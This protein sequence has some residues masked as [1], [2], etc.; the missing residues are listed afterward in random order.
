MSYFDH[1]TIE[2]LMIYSLSSLFNSLKNEMPAVRASQIIYHLN[3]LVKQHAL[4]LKSIK[5][6]DKKWVKLELE[7]ENKGNV[8]QI[9]ALLFNFMVDRDLLSYTNDLSTDLESQSII[10]AKRELDAFLSSFS[11]SF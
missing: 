10:G 11:L 4:L 5:E 6:K 1:Y 8:Y 7:N 9:G 2:A 3:K